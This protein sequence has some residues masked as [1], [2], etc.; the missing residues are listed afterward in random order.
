M[1]IYDEYFDELDRA[2]FKAHVIPGIT[3]ETARG[4][5]WG[6]K[7]HCSFC[8]ISDSG[9]VFRAKPSEQVIGELDALYA[10]HGINRFVT[11]DNIIEPSYFNTLM[12]A[13]VAA[14]RDFALFYQTKAN[15]KRHQVAL[16]ADAGVRWIQP[17]IESLDDRVLPLLAKGASAAINVQLI[18]WARNYGVWLLWNMLFG[19]PGE[20]DAWYT[21]LATWLPLIFH[22]QPPA[23]G[24]LTAIRYN[25][26]SP[27]FEKPEQFGINLVP[28]WAYQHTY[29]HDT[30]RR[31][32][33]AY[34]FNDTRDAANSARPWTRPGVRAVNE[35][36]REWTE[37]FI[38]H[39]SAPIATMRHDAPILVARP[40]GEHLII[41]DTRPCAVASRHDLTALET[42]VYKVCDA[43]RTRSG[44]VNACAQAGEPVAAT[45]V[46]EIVESLIERKLMHELGDRILSLATDEPVAYRNPHD[47]PAGLLLRQPV[48]MKP[49]PS[50]WDLPLT[51]LPDM[52]S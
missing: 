4:C 25:R 28:N 16:L 7:E 34:Y 33:Q 47:F 49:P 35:R 1:P 12:P 18:K 42:R 30:V 20:N 19:A 26:F 23:A 10:R 46:D 13:L 21:E 3:I 31:A 52:F 39:E 11:A 6:Q 22:L 38:D 24:E 2:R 51:R 5:W 17:G 9:M 36:I 32:Q 14:D 40:S 44:I 27:Y 29:P 37:L 15:L 8:G 48:A 41:R 50:P 43:A 45:Q